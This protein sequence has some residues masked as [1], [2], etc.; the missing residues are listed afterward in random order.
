MRTVQI[1]RRISLI[2]TPRPGVAFIIVACGV[3]ALDQLTKS[4][5]RAY[6]H[7][8]DSIPLIEGVLHI[9][10]VRNPG[11]AFGLM[12]GARPLFIATFLIVIVGAVAYWVKEKPNTKWV[13]TSLALFTS[14][15][16][17]NFIDRLILGK[18][19][20]FI[21]FT[22]IDWPIFNFADV[23]IVSGIAMLLFWV[24]TEPAEK[25]AAEAISA[26]DL[27]DSDEPR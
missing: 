19:T 26:Q 8:S 11:A 3:L 5:V 27:G 17:G 16:S 10:H 23:G 15:A 2:T 13:V 12:P 6:L 14:G 18:V 21:D 9:T 20:D 1:R 25:P 7:A 4:M 24:L 22:L